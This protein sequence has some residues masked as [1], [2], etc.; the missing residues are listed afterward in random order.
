MSTPSFPLQILDLEQELKK[1]AGEDKKFYPNQHSMPIPQID[2]LD[3]NPPVEL[4]QLNDA[5]AAMAKGQN[6]ELNPVMQLEKIDEGDIAELS[7]GQDDDDEKLTG[8]E[9][10]LPKEIE[11]EAEK[12][13][14]EL[15]EEEDDRKAF[16]DGLMDS[17]Q[18]NPELLNQL[19][20]GLFIH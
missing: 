20:R 16:M 7:K 8:N 3:D 2:G 13:A 11:N 9:E 5:A 10:D 19:M 4:Q 12:D 14:D 1:Q 18:R 15:L 17:L 6:P